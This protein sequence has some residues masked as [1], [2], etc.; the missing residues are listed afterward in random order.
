[1]DGGGTAMAADREV[2][3]GFGGVLHGRRENR[4]VPQHREKRGR[5]SARELTKGGT[6]RRHGTGAAELRR[7]GGGAEEST[8]C[9]SPGSFFGTCARERRAGEKGYPRRAAAAETRDRGGEAYLGRETAARAW[10][11]GMDCPFIAAHPGEQNGLSG[12]ALAHG[13]PGVAGAGGS[14]SGLCG[15]AVALSARPLSER[16]RWGCRGAGQRRDAAA[17]GGSTR[18]AGAH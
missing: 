16:G 8:S 3:V 14:D 12:G 2:R 4:D 11:C 15:R 17:A 1:V 13:R 7:S 5:G 18:E 9:T 10:T 6:W